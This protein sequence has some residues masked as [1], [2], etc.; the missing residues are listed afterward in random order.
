[1]AEAARVCGVN[2]V[3][4]T[5][6]D[7]LPDTGVLQTMINDIDMLLPGSAR[8]RLTSHGPNMEDVKCWDSLQNRVTSGWPEQLEDW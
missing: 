3:A 1:M 8:V 6:C 7:Y 5:F 2:T 4:L